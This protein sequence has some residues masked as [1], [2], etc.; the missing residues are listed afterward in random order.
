LA[1]IVV[2]LVASAMIPP[3][4][5]A[6]SCLAMGAPCISSVQCCSGVCNTGLGV[7]V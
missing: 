6:G 7:C 4:I 1:G 2:P 5:A 3:A